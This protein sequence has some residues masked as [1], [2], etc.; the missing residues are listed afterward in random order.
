VCES[1]AQPGPCPTGDSFY[2]GCKDA[3]P[4]PC[5]TFNISPGDSFYAG[6]NP[7]CAG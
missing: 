1:G 7:L 3:Q 4:N 6:C 5:L 2:A